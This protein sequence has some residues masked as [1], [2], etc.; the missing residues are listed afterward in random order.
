MTHH[1]DLI[2]DALFSMGSI[3]TST[4]NMIDIRRDKSDASLLGAVLDS[5]KP[6]D[7]S[8]PSLTTMLLYD[9]I[10][11]SLQPGEMLTDPV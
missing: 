9:G 10:Q 8:S 11:A 4:V 7:G 1:I 6:E 3:N 5:L 2:S